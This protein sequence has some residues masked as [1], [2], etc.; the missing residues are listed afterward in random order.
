M[1]QTKNSKQVKTKNQVLK[2]KIINKI[3]QNKKPF[4]EKEKKYISKKNIILHKTNKS[5]ASNISDKSKLLR[6]EDSNNITISYNSGHKSFINKKFLSNSCQKRENFRLKNNKTNNL[7]NK[8]KYIKHNKLSSISPDNSTNTKK[9]LEHL[10]TSKNKN[11][12]SIIYET[13]NN[14]NKFTK[15]SN[16][17][18]VN[19]IIFRNKNSL[20]S[21]KLLNRSVELRNKIKQLKLDEKTKIILTKNKSNT[22]N[23][24]NVKKDSIINKENKENK[25]YNDKENESLDD[26][27]NYSEE[28]CQTFSNKENNN[29][30][31]KT[32]KNINE[33]NKEKYNTLRINTNFEKNIQKEISKI[34]TSISNGGTKQ[35]KFINKNERKKPQQPQENKKLK[36]LIREFCINNSSLNNNKIKFINKKET[37]NNGSFTKRNRKKSFNNN[38]SH[39]ILTR[40]NNDIFE[41]MSDIKVKSY[42]EYKQEKEKINIE[43]TFEKN[44][45]PINNNININININYNTINVNDTNPLND[46]FIKDRD[47]Y[48]NHIKETFSKDRFSFKPINNEIV[49]DYECFNNLTKEKKLNKMD[50][51]PNNKNKEKKRIKIKHKNRNIKREVNKIKKNISNNKINQEKVSLNK[52]IRLNKKRK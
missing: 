9:S 52:S 3:N 19:K 39:K 24:I 34:K 37:K 46:N 29:S 25:E 11:F 15:I 50:F 32:N 5:L 35:K 47:E 44:N 23:K 7:F 22:K 49:N 14:F 8:T 48:N 17:I 45:N 1:E 38:D 2:P 26:K 40:N 21:N 10:K 6:K 51:I 41:I 12:N 43:K 33:K 16:S 20:N 28:V 18:K 30:F 13:C 4:L 42:H 31:E 36:Y 27:N